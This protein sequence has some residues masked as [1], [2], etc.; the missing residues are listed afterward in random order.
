MQINKD[1]ER[2]YW[3][4]NNWL[5]NDLVRIKCY[6]PSVSHEVYIGINSNDGRTINSIEDYWYYK[7]S[8]NGELKIWS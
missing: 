3:K 6:T 5:I 8:R 4:N 1:W 7:K 2:V